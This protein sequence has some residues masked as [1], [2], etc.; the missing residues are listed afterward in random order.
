MRD[1]RLLIRR[2]AD[3]GM[4]VLLSSHLLA[5][6]E[7]VCNRVAIVRSGR[8]VY[9]GDDRRAQARRRHDLPARDHRRRA[10][11]GG[12]PRPAGHRRRARSSTGGSRFTADEA[13]VAELSQALIEAGALI[14]ALAPADGHARGPVLLAHRG[15][16]ASTAPS[17]RPRAE[18]A[19]GDRDEP[20]ASPPSTAGS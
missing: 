10:R 11:A 16:R 18:P 17:R 7:E 15:R 12:L 5:E 14:T 9:E 1:M 13:A 2:L 3:Q 8:I 4:T 19:R 6:V 20:P